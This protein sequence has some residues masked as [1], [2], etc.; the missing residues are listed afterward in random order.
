MIDTIKPMGI[1]L[2]KNLHGHV[3]VE[4]RDRWTGRVVD[5]Q[6]KDNLVTNA[7]Q[8][9]IMLSGYTARS[10]G[11]TYS[12]LYEKTLG[13]IFLFDNTL[14]ESASNISFPS[15]AKV[16]GYAGQTAN[17][18]SNII[19]S[20]N[21]QE[22]TPISNGFT[23]VWD[24]LTSQAN[25]AIA[26][27]ART[28]PY[29][30]GVDGNAGWRSDADFH[31]DYG[32]PSTALSSYAWLGYDEANG[33]MYICPT[34]SQTIEGVTYPASNIYRIS[35]DLFKIHLAN[36]V[37]AASQ[38]TLIKTLTSSDGYATA[39]FW[40]YDQYANN[41]VYMSGNTIH[42]VAMDGAH[43]TKSVSG[44]GSGSDMAVTENYYWRVSSGTVYRITKTN[45]ADVQAYTLA[46]S[47]L[48]VSAAENDVVFAHPYSSAGV[49]Q[50]LYPDGTIITSGTASRDQATMSQFGSSMYCMRYSSGALK[51]LYASS[52]YLGTIAN[53]DAPVTK[54]SSQTMKIIYTLTEA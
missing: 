33:Y 28:S 6:E 54:S 16:V 12:P 40:T 52:H 11:Q 31:Y 23:T 15:S 45:T 27:L 48:Y 19:G 32:S 42:L 4:L 44:T 36:N 9:M 35:G 26:S 17:T 5:S 25:G 21:A 41:F 37:P 30:G 24:F 1:D 29:W 18:D 7:V 51:S 38:M 20:Y 47:G 10:L 34:S 8:K 53:L 49:M 50:V 43:T 2:T 39:Y 14:T 22:S 3:R 46:A 13:G